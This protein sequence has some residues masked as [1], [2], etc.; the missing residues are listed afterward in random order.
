MNFV[1][2]VK[3][4]KIYNVNTNLLPWR[5]F[6][7]IIKEMQIIFCAIHI[8]VCVIKTKLMHYLSLVYFVI[9]PLHDL[10]VFV[11]HHQKVYYIYTTIGTC[12]IYTVHLLMMGYKYARNM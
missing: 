1:F 9:Q 11:A 6:T 12:C 5:T 4:Q 10:G 7:R 8:F 2:I 3:G